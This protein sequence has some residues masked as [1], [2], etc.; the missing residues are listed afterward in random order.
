MYFEY[1]LDPD[2]LIDSALPKML[3][4]VFGKDTGRMLT[5]FQEPREW[6]L[7]IQAEIKRRKADDTIRPQHFLRLQTM[8]EPLLKTPDARNDK[9]FPAHPKRPSYDSRASWSTNVLTAHRAVPFAAIVTNDKTGTVAP[10][11]V[12]LKDPAFSLQPSA[13]VARNAPALVKLLDSLLCVS[14]ELVL[15]D[16]HFQPREARFQALLPE[17]FSAHPHFLQAEIYL[18]ENYQRPC[19][20]GDF[21]DWCIPEHSEGSLL[22]PG[23]RLRITVLREHRQGEK[24]HARY[25]LTEVGGVAVDPGLDVDMRP[26]SGNTFLVTRLGARLHQELWREYVQRTGFQRVNEFIVNG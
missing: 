26:N 19:T 16:P 25:L 6:A 2:G 12:D 3:F 13:R 9:F 18:K 23:E 7:Y 21:S 1:A 11:D 8:L 5:S 10:D 4:D 14:S 22:L 20:P 15:I 17:I 24:L